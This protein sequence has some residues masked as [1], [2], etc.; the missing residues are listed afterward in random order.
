MNIFVVFETEAGR[1]HGAFISEKRARNHMNALTTRHR[2]EV[3][4]CARREEIPPK[5]F[6]VVFETELTK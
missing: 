1:T 3:V 2:H 5:R 4:E 6:Y